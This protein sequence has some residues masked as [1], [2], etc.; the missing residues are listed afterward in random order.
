MNRILGVPVAVF[1]LIAIP[2]LAASPTEEPEKS[3][4]R[5]AALTID[6]EGDEG[7]ADPYEFKVRAAGPAPA[8]AVLSDES[9]LHTAN[10]RSV[11][12]CGGKTRVAF[13]NPT[14]T[15]CL[16]LASVPTGHTLTSD[17]KSTTADK[18]I[19]DS[20]LKLTVNR[21]DE[22]WG[23][24][25]AILLLGIVGG[26]V[27]TL[28]KPALRSPIRRSVLGSLLVKNERHGRISG[29]REFV[30]A[31]LGAGES[32]DALIEKANSL[33]KRGP[34]V[35]SKARDELKRKLAELVDSGSLP[36]NHPLVLAARKEAA[37]A[38]HNVADFYDAEG[39]RI[40]HPAD[41]L[42]TALTEL[43]AYLGAIDGLRVEVDK[44]DKEVRR[45]PAIAVQRAQIAADRMATRDAG[46][47]VTALIAE[48]R[49][50][51]D[52]ALATSLVR[53]A[54]GRRGAG[55]AI[56]DMIAAAPDPDAVEIG[57]DKLTATRIIAGFWTAVVLLATLGFAVLTIKYETYEPNLT[58]ASLGDYVGLAVAALASGAAGGVILWVGYWFPSGAAAPEGE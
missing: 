35:A 28:G 42:R 53:K 58:F 29:L 20:T 16:R 14:T 2:S 48:A 22:F 38:D 6:L 36:A 12:E 40:A 24:P 45:P 52:A 18:T 4:V 33:V 9:G 7:G 54:A 47:Q 31:R 21:R 49:G 11:I 30:S 32:V 44:L 3:A 13:S 8:P 19:A 25:L 10:A 34:G 23:L 27:A 41:E 46:T 26:V 39:A 55:A 15:W 17:L 37:R 50:S 5:E 51:I 56:A 1:V 57:G 43:A